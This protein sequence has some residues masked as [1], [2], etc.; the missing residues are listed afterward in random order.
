[1]AVDIIARG[2][3]AK[4]QEKADSLGTGISFK[5]EVSSVSQLP[6]PSASTQGQLF[7][8][9]EA[10]TTTSDFVDG[11]GISIPAGTTIGIVEVNG[12]YKYDTFGQIFYPV[13]Y[14]AFLDMLVNY[15][16]GDATN[17]ALKS[18]VDSLVGAINTVLDSVNGVVI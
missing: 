11:A 6:A 4:A 14:K 16:N 2:M 17:I 9:T 5:G 15:T 12:Q 3:A 1:M 13:E 7:Y 18:Y 8:L 10:G